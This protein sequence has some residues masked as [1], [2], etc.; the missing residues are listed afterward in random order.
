[1]RAPKLGTS[2]RTANSQKTKNLVTMQA[3]VSTLMGNLALK[4]Y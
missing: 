2:L 3:V 1:M 4:Y